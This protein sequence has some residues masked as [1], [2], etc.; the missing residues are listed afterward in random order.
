MAQ[1]RL[2]EQGEGMAMLA[3]GRVGE[4]GMTSWGG[5]G[6]RCRGDETGRKGNMEECSGDKSEQ[7]QVQKEEWKAERRNKQL[8]NSRLLERCFEDEKTNKNGRM[9]Q[10]RKDRCARE[11][12]G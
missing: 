1:S 7:R 5:R 3:R 2:G 8:M 4:Q 12:R 10:E 11:G 6:G 9:R